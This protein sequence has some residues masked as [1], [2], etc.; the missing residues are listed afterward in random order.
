MFN[1]IVY[2]QGKIKK[3]KRNP[4]YVSGSLVMEISSNIKFEKKDVG[5][6]VCCDGVCLT[7]IG[8]RK[9]SF[10][11]Y[12]SKETLQK[13]NFK[14]AK[15]GNYINIEKSISHGK[16]IS[17]H[18][19]QGHVDTASIVK[20]IKIIDKSWIINFNLEKKFKNFIIEKGS[21]SI[22]GVSLTVSKVKKNSFETTIIPHTLK[23]TNLINLKKGDLVNIE[24]DI[25]GKY[26]FNLR[27]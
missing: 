16:K 1:G 20:G 14:K 2:K 3:M 11:F 19:I 18:Y 8:I 26:L 21:I 24:F 7:L 17:G 15:I 22:N 23:L 10:F 9:R 25:F 27:K 12:L 5:E 6:S 4:K 13:S